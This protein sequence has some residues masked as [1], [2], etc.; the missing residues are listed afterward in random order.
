MRPGAGRVPGSPW[1]LSPPRLG[2]RPPHQS[3]CGCW[4]GASGPWQARGGCLPASPWHRASA[5]ASPGN[6]TDSAGRALSGPCAATS[7]PVTAVGSRPPGPGPTPT[8]SSPPSWLL[9]SARPA[10]RF[11]IT[12]AAAGGSGARRAGTTCASHRGGASVCH[13]RSGRCRGCGGA[14][15]RRAV[16]CAPGSVFNGARPGGAWTPPVCRGRGF[17]ACVRLRV[18]GPR[19]SL[20]RLLRVCHPEACP[21]VHMLGMSVDKGVRPVG[22]VPALTDVWVHILGSGHQTQRREA[23]PRT[24][25]RVESA[26]GSVPEPMWDEVAAPC[27]CGSVARVC[28][29]VCDWAP[30]AC[31]RPAP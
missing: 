29:C 24:P 2:Q 19:A 31:A 4:R 9:P 17:S 11:L 13:V 6:R 18:L 1:E 3:C 26:V 15:G 10:P 28:A 22:P 8:I 7:R 21:C 23:G 25:A 16:P 30:R 5:R 14:V 20:Q 12:H 27:A